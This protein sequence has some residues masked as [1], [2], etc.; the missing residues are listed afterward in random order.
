M[1]HRQKHFT[2][3]KT[4]IGVALLSVMKKLKEFLNPQ[5]KTVLNSGGLHV[6]MQVFNF[7]LWKDSFEQQLPRQ[8]AIQADRFIVQMSTHGTI[9]LL[10]GC[11]IDIQA[12]SAC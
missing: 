11:M 2:A 6:H 12:K 3:V 10:P 9:C 8:V 7:E 4:A 1:S 5:S